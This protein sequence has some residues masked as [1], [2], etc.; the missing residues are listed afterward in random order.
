LVVDPC[1]VPTIGRAAGIA[2][3]AIVSDDV[4]AASLVT[5]TRATVRRRW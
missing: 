5:G 3:G 4:P 2:A 1:P